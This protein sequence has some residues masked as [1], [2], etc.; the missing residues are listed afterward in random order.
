MT[1]LYCT[2]YV[3]VMIKVTCSSMWSVKSEMIIEKK[4]LCDSILSK[5][6]AYIQDLVFNMRFPL[7]KF[8]FW[9]AA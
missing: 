8:G 9:P 2:I 3:T 5:I 7:S 4:L 6:L 1:S